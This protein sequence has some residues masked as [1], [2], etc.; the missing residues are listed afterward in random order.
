MR[1]AHRR[2]GNG[3][4]GDERQGDDGWR[5][6]GR[7]VDWPCLVPRR[8]LR[9]RQPL[10]PRCVL[11]LLGCWW[12]H[13]GGAR[14]G[15]RGGAHADGTTGHGGGAGNAFVRDV[16]AR[17]S[18]DPFLLDLI[19]G[20]VDL[21]LFNPAEGGGEPAK[22]PIEFAPPPAALLTLVYD[23]NGCALWKCQEGRSRT[24]DALASPRAQCLRVLVRPHPGLHSRRPGVYRIS[25]GCLPLG[26][27][28]WCRPGCRCW[29]RLGC[30]CWYR[31]G[32]RRWCRLGCRCGCRLG[33]RCGY[34]LGC[35]CW[36]RLGCRCW[37][38]LRRS[39]WCRLGCRCWR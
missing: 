19:V 17:G 4:R 18:T 35:R 29:C 39:C 3:R 24:G 27:R 21:H 38:R 30:R 8:L 20:L 31:L 14:G 36:C 37:Y 2:R 7:R 25:Q 26:C 12:G 32:W 23:H 22:F 1:R 9:L 11:G 34:R 10:R 6:D 13:G 28:C 15:A 16:C 33:C 5:G